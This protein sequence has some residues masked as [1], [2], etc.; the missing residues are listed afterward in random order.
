MYAVP[1]GI[2]LMKG[3]SSES[4]A[5]LA[6]GLAIWFLLNRVLRRGS[7]NQSLRVDYLSNSLVIMP[8]DRWSTITKKGLALAV[9]L[10]GQLRVVHLETEG[11]D[12]DFEALWERNVI[13]P[14]KSADRAVPELVRLVSQKGQELQPIAN[15]ILAA[16]RDQPDRQIIVVLSEL[17]VRHWWQKPLHN[18]RNR[19]LRLILSMRGSPRIITI[20][21]P[22]SL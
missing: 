20:N 5:V 4:I 13:F 3:L 1:I 19:L 17:G 2:S 10:K 9:Q 15:Y 6:L 7:F 16:E 12:K 8:L 22:W 18:N 21:V 11:T 14:L